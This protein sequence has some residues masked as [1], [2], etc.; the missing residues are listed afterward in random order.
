VIANNH[1]AVRTLGC[2]TVFSI[3]PI[4]DSKCLAMVD[5]V[6]LFRSDFE[7]ETVVDMKF[8]SSPSKFLTLGNKGSIFDFNLEHGRKKV[9]V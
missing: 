4:D 9:L 6:D 7:D 1:L 5:L 3:K 8:P 2:V